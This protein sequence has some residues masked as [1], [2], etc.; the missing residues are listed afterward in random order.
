MHEFNT[1]LSYFSTLEYY[2]IIEWLTVY[3][4]LQTDSN[5]DSNSQSNGAV[6]ATA[7]VITFL[8][9]LITTV[10]ITFIVI[11]IFVKSKF[12]SISKD[13]TTKQPAVT[14]DTDTVGLPNQTSSTA[15][16]E[17]VN[18]ACNESLRVVTDT[19]PANESCK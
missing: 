17:V 13:T 18:P 3:D 15:D 12:A 16:L 1:L 8:V 6:V 4:I 11:Y 19:D 14:S 10:T 9:T 2:E 5:S 7:C